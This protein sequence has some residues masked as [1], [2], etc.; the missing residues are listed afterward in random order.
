MRLVHGKLSLNSALR[1]RSP[2]SSC[3]ITKQLW[4]VMWC[5]GVSRF[6]P[7]GPTDAP[8]TQR[9][10]RFPHQSLLSGPLTQWDTPRLLS[11]NYWYL[12]STAQSCRVMLQERAGPQVFR[13]TQLQNRK[14]GGCHGGLRCR[15]PG[16]AGGML[17]SGRDHWLHVLWGGLLVMWVHA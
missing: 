1:L 6:W 11:T 4:V 8:A 12:N 16:R 13:C 14:S 10:T 9:S 5:K 2:E 7:P 17:R 3:H 15:S